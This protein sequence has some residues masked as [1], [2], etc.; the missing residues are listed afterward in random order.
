MTADIASSLIWVWRTLSHTFC[1][2]PDYLAPE[3]IRGTGY[4]WGVDYWGLGVLL[5]ELFTG[6]APFHS[7]YTTGTGKKILNG[8]VKFP[9]K[10]TGPMKDLI[11]ALL[12]K[13]QMRRLGVLKGGTEDVMKHRFYTG[14]DMGR[15][16]EYA[17]TCPI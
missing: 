7:Y 11:K 13:D 8:V 10:M 2:T 9:E 17:K 1:G 5:Y 14:F 15:T 12:T 4:N 3:V 16:V 6:K